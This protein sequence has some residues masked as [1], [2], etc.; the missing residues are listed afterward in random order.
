MEVYLLA[1]IAVCCLVMATA[2]RDVMRLADDI[3]E[4]RGDIHAIVTMLD[5]EDARKAMLEIL[6]QNPGVFPNG[7]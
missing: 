3:R 4:M 7:D 6:K 5:K 1:F 2:V